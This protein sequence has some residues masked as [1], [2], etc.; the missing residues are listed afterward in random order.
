M[1]FVKY[2]ESLY[3]TLLDMYVFVLYHLLFR[4]PITDRVWRGIGSLPRFNYFPTLDHF[5]EKVCML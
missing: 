3:V 4:S 5:D 2:P 1:S